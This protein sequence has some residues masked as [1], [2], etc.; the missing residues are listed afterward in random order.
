[1]LAIQLGN[2]FENSA[3]TGDVD[4]HSVTNVGD[5]A[6]ELSYFE[7]DLAAVGDCNKILRK[8]MSISKLIMSTGR[9]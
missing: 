2:P 7:S 3:C 4:N 5:V 9:R 6:V 1:M 8:E